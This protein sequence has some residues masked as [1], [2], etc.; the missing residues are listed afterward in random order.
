MVL[1]RQWIGAK[2]TNMGVSS[3]SKSVGTTIPIARNIHSFM[4]ANLMRIF[5][6]A[7]EYNKGIVWKRIVKQNQSSRLAVGIDL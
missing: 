4:D 2:T 3:M 5:Q 1:L 7:K 6:S